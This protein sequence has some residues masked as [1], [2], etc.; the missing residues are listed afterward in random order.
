MDYV[1]I[2]STGNATDF[3]DLDLGRAYGGQAS[4]QTRGLYMGGEAA[5][6]NTTNIQYITIASTGNSTSFGD[7]FEQ[8][9]QYF[10]GCSNGHGGLS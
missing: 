5:P 1:T 3:G 9:Q 8:A 7:L 6:S 2:A 4:N 10:N